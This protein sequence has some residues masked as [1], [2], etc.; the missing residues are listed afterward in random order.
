MKKAVEFKNVSFCYNNSPQVLSD[1][2]F[3]LNY[4]EITLLTGESGQGKSTVLSV[5]A[6]IIPTAIR[7]VSA[8]SCHIQMNTYP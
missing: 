4:C 7:R 5:I 1:V 6:G 3:T 2:S 8:L